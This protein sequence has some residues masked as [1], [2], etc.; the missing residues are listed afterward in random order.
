MAVVQ[1]AGG[2]AI[3]QTTL[4]GALITI[5]P[6]RNWFI[7][8]FLGAWTGGW[9][10]GGGMALRNLFE[11]G[12]PL[13]A[14]GF[15]LFWLC[16]WAVALWF[17]GRTLYLQFF[18]QELISATRDLLT[19]T[20]PG[21][22]TTRPASYAINEVRRLRT[23]PSSGTAGFFRPQG[24]PGHGQGALVFDHGMRSVTF[25]SGIDEPE[26][27]HILDFLRD[28]GLINEANLA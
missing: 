21:R 13:F 11:P 6:R 20:R 14:R 24:F 22:W 18:G 27:R 16:G 3:I 8:L 17:V 4:N 25:A 1:P 10:F 19:I 5:P 12:M 9:T 7:I 28:Q 26:A 15:L 2:R 23:A